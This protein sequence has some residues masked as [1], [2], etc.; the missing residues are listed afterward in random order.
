MKT[1]DVA[2][3]SCGVVEADITDFWETFPDLLFTF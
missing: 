1:Q 2:A 3:K